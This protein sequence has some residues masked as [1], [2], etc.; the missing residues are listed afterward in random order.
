M[1]SVVITS[2]FL[3][4]FGLCFSAYVEKSHITEIAFHGAVLK[5]H[6]WC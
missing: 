5:E 1:Y 3:E 6:A 2:Y 4:L